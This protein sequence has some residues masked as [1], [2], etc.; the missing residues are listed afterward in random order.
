MVDKKMAERILEVIVDNEGHIQTLMN[1]ILD[2][3]PISRKREAERLFNRL[4]KRMVFRDYL[5]TCHGVVAGYER[6]PG[7]DIILDY[8]QFEEA[9]TI[10]LMLHG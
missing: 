1:E 3:V 8:D 9:V 4:E 6:V 10:A 7:S 2:L 5:H